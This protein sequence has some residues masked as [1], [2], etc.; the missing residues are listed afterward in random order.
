MEPEKQN[1]RFIALD[2][3]R[4]L[5]IL[6]V[7]LNHI[8]KN[9]IISST[10]SWLLP[11]VQTIFSSGVVAVSI[12]F[13][14]CGFLM[15]YLYS[16]PKSEFLQKRYTRIF[17][18]FVS[19]STAMALI[20]VHQETWQWYQKLGVVFLIAVLVHL[21]W[22]H[23]VKKVN[24]P[25]ISKAIFIF[26][27]LLQ[28]FAFFFYTFYIMR[29]SA[30][31]F[32]SVTPEI[33]RSV[34]IWLVNTTLTLP[35]GTYIPML[36]GVY[37]SLCTE[38]LFYILFPFICI[39]IVKK[40]E[41]KSQTIKI[42]F[43]LSI[44]LLLAGL[45]IIFKNILGL[46]MLQIP[47]FFYFITGMSLGYLYKSKE[48][49][50]LKLRTIPF[51]PLAIPVF[52]VG[53]NLTVEQIVTVPRSV[54]VLLWA[55][56]ITLLVAMALDTKSNYSKML[57]NKLLV[58]LG[59]ISYSLYLSHTIVISFTRDLYKATNIYE[60]IFFIV[61]TF[62]IAVIVSAILNYLL[63]QPYFKRSPALKQEVKPIHISFKKAA[64]GISVVYVLFILF[65]YQSSFN[66][67]S[68]EKGHQ[69]SNISL[70]K[71]PNVH[72]EFTATERNLGIVTLKVI[73]QETAKPETLQ[74]QELVFKIKEKG[75]K[76]WHAINTY[77]PREINNQKNY[78]FGFPVIIDSKNKTYEIELS[79]SKPE[80]HQFVT[81]KKDSL[82][83]V[84]SAD[85][86]S[87]L[88]QPLELAYH[89]GKKVNTI[90]TNSEAQLTF[91]L[92]IPAIG[93]LLFL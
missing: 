53:W 69:N 14:L 50:V 44:V 15:S 66:F 31:I 41:T 91:M 13:V 78:P 62:I 7:F 57:E 27:L 72:M 32:Y 82:R 43:L 11:L 71:N 17:P 8:D 83:S 45:D 29:Q 65:A 19:M 73:Y 30:S 56:P 20:R 76:D 51:A 23:G 75:A 92:G 34:S 59:R 40:L 80:L 5:A 55:I 25:K 93:M 88:K 46:S 90:I 81:I 64:I 28:G 61:L 10:P 89:V 67:F 54:L 38:V 26:F 63:E 70:N 4:G 42:I 58:Y 16:N 12:L 33:V 87:L 79:L 68:I 21:I 85:K 18:L 1:A 49:I 24:N 22:V 3:L 84:Y 77:N 39:P 9:Y 48:A 74:K 86:G 6:F 47:L 2:G 35:F 52:F 37:W 60:N 36:D